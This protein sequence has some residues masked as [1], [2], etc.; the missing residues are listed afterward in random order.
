MNSYVVKRVSEL[1]W[2]TIEKVELVHQP[3]LEPCDIKA[4][5]QACHDT[6]ALH[7]RMCARE[8][9]IRATMTELLSPVHLDSCLEFFFSPCPGDLRYFN[10]EVNQ[11]GAVYVGFGGTNR[12]MRMRQIA[13]DAKAIF[14][15]N[16]FET[17]D[18]WGVEIR[19]PLEFMQMFIPGYAFEGEAAGNFYKCGDQTE[20]PHF[21]AWSALSSEKPDFHRPT[22]FGRLIFE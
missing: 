20:I 21:L 22:D 16:T 3:W 2:D 8:A 1:N 4:W 10:F 19:I 7:I 18:G 11:L 17:Q 15:L 13:K 14:G 6:Q 12:A 5:A 9:N